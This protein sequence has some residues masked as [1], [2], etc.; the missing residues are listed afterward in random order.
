MCLSAR[1]KTFFFR[2]LYSSVVY[3][4]LRS[5]SL[6]RFCWARYKE[7]WNT[8][9]SKMFSSRRNRFPSNFFRTRS[10]VVFRISTDPERKNSCKL[11]RNRWGTR[12]ST[13]WALSVFAARRINKTA[14]NKRDA[15]G[16]NWS[17]RVVNGNVT[18]GRYIVCTFV[19]SLRTSG[20]LL[21]I[22]CLLSMDATFRE[23]FV[24][25]IKTPCYRWI[26]LFRGMILPTGNFLISHSRLFR[27]EPGG[28]GVKW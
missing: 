15:N 9:A 24:S 6:R 8:W 1:G 11:C 3:G 22:S 16:L 10:G 25:A 21:R 2:V 12:K 23:A 14:G 5:R 7:C 27:A 28:W 19:K 20:L 18:V 4:V 17:I 13:L 26:F